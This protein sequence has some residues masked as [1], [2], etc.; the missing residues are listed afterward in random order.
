M[1]AYSASETYPQASITPPPVPSHAPIQAL[2]ELGQFCIQG[3]IE[4]FTRT[5]NSS[6]IASILHDNNIVDLSGVM[7]QAIKL[8]RTCFVKEL[9]RH[10]VPLFPIYISEAINA[11][12][13]AKDILESLLENGWDINQPMGAM[14][15]P[16]LSDALDDLEM[17]TWLL[18]HGADPN[19]RCNIDFTPLSYAIEHASLPIVNLLLNR[20]GDVTKGQVLHHAVARESDAV[21]VLKLLIAQGA[22]INGIM[23][24]DHQPSWDMYLFMGETPLHKAVFLR[25]VDV[26]HYL[27]GEGA[28]LN[29][30]DVRNRT[31]LQCADEDI[32]REITKWSQ[33]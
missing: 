24:R 4:S 28:E 18:D 9:L 17:T 27:L 11:K 21:E 22:P 16:I 3:D 5:L 29:V 32:R 19:R 14:H 10:E 6:S 7:T 26:I 25:K 30:K 23:Y 31:A 2:Q 12:E 13:N 1:I 20:G 33:Y 15:P 8:G